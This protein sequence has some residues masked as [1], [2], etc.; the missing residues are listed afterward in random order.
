M[1]KVTMKVSVLMCAYHHRKFMESRMGLDKYVE[2]GWD[3][4][5]V[6]KYRTRDQ[7]S[8]TARAATCGWCRKKRISW[9]KEKV[10]PY[11]VSSSDE[12]IEEDG[13][14]GRWNGV[15]IRGVKK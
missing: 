7:T 10:V 1:L 9:G 3:N 8:I 13:W 2:Y 4:D 11:E 5:I 6:H 14:D 15:V 12:D